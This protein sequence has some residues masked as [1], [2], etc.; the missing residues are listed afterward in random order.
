MAGNR[1]LGEDGTNPMSMAEPVD[2]P[3]QEG[4]AG[5]EEAQTDWDFYGGDAQAL[6]DAVVQDF[7]AGAI[8]V[9]DP[10]DADGEEPERCI[11]LYAASETSA[12]DSGD[13]TNSVSVTIAVPDTA[14]RTLAVLGELG[15]RL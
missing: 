13:E 4:A 5:R 3:A 14:E 9:R 7:Q 6:W 12:L 2:E 11:T 10:W 8:G 1:V 15:A